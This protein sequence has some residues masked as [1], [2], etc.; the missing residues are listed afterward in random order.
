MKM[1]GSRSA[2]PTILEQR[3][4]GECPLSLAF[5]SGSSATSTMTLKSTYSTPSILGPE[6]FVSMTYGSCWS[7]PKL[8]EQEEEFYQ[9]KERLRRESKREQ[10]EFIKFLCNDPFANR[11]VGQAVEERRKGSKSPIGGGGNSKS[12]VIGTTK[13]EE[14]DCLGFCSSPLFDY[15]RH[16]ESGKKSEL[17]LGDQMATATLWEKV[18]LKRK[19]EE[20]ARCAMSLDTV[21]RKNHYDF[22]SSFGKEEAWAEEEEI[23]SEGE[24]EWKQYLKTVV[25][26][27]K[28][29]IFDR[30]C[31]NRPPS[32]Q[33][34]R[35]KTIC[36]PLPNQQRRASEG[37]VG[38]SN[39]YQSVPTSTLSFS[40]T[41]P[42]TISGRMG[43][44]RLQRSFELNQFK[45]SK[46]FISYR[47][48]Q[49]PPP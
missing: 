37:M 24:D 44:S 47:S 14:G 21:L 3:E 22:R 13:G 38:D 25:D 12:P 7:T 43:A 9:S 42:A 33:P 41:F 27:S 26:L 49:M 19:N 36:V 18:E 40:S 15:G 20:V 39:H 6:E 1:G 45:Q 8:F 46:T 4:E 48:R 35:R 10:R 34:I 29:D 16:M 30:R 17:M 2:T 5:D 32:P 11:V 28:N 31:S 23:E